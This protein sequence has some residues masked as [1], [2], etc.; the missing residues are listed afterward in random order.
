[1][2]AQARAEREARAV[3]AVYQGRAGSTKKFEKE[4]FPVVRATAERRAERLPEGLGSND[5][6]RTL[7]RA[8]FRLCGVNSSEHRFPYTDLEARLSLI[9]HWASGNARTS[10]DE[11]IRTFGVPKSMQQRHFE[12][13]AASLGRASNA[14]ESVKSFLSA[15]PKEDIA[16]AVYRLHFPATGR[17]PLFSSEE[18]AAVMAHCM[19]ESF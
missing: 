18:S 4:F 9:G 8:A 16:A 19:E 12:L 1:M 15:L 11:P 14:E 13:L 2:D 3:M 5:D 10:W 7:D 17:K 6:C